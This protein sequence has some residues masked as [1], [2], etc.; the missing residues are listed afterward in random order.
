[1][2]TS[3]NEELLNEDTP[4]PTYDFDD[5]LSSEELSLEEDDA[6]KENS[7][8]FAQLLGLPQ[9]TIETIY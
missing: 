3:E 8:K 2:I 6:F 9:I 7:N 4:E 5:G 1:L